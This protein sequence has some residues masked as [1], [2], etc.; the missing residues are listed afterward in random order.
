MRIIKIVRKLLFIIL[1]SITFL[2]FSFVTIFGL[3]L[4]YSAFFGS[5]IEN[6]A[7]FYEKTYAIG[8]NSSSHYLYNRDSGEILLEN[9]VGYLEEDDRVYVLNRANYVT[10][11][12]TD[13]TVKIKRRIEATE[14]ENEKFEQI[15]KLNSS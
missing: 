3:L 5:G 15:N 10:I 12:T 11:H 7:T 6:V 9:V 13:G 8:V 2:Y 14:Q 1:I 4:G